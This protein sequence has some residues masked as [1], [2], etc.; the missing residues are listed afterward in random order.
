ML[1][2]K[3]A[4]YRQNVAIIS[5]LGLSEFTYENKKWKIDFTN[6]DKVVDIFISEGVIGRIEGGHIGGRAG[7][8]NSQFVVMVPNDTAN[9]AEKFDMLPITDPRAQEFY[10]QFFTSLKSHLGK[11]DG[12]NSTCST[13]PMNQ[14]SRILAAIYRLPDSLKALYPTFRLLKPV[15]V[16][17]WE[18]YSIY[19]CRS[20]IS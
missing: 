20:S 18:G 6:F 9:L 10:R 13:S 3:M 15:T 19:G 4:E 8:W 2:S 17:I 16:K 7:G 1:A 5:P 12:I 14:Q 11:K